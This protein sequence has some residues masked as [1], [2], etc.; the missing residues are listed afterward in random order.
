M[1]LWSSCDNSDDLRNVL[2]FHMVFCQ[3]KHLHHCVDMPLFIWS[4][5]LANLANLVRKLFL[6]LIISTN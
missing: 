4:I 3:G 2:F 1:Q 5:L 6:E